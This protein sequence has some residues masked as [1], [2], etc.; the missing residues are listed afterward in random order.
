MIQFDDKNLRFILNSLD[1]G[2][3]I[4]NQEGYTIFY[5]R[6]VS[7]IDGLDP[8]EVLG[9]NV[10]ETYP[11]LTLE[12]STLMKTLKENKGISN[13]QQTFIN[14]RGEKITTI[15]STIPLNFE[16]GE[17]GAM[18]VSRDITQLKELVNNI[19]ALR[20]DII[21]KRQKKRSIS[22]KSSNSTSYSFKDIVGKSKT[23]QKALQMAIKAADSDSSVLLAGETGTGKE[24]F[25]QGIHSASRRNNR[26]FIA[27]NC[28]A[29]PKD[30]L[31]GLLFGTEK[32]GFTGARSRAGLFEDADGGSILL[33][34]INA[35][36]PA[37][38]AKLLRV[39][40][41]KKVR[42]IGGQ[43]EID[44]NVRIIATINESAEKTLKENKLREDLFYRLSV[45][46]I[47][48][49]PLRERE[50]DIQL[51]TEH[52]INNYNKKFSRSIKG[53]TVEMRKVFNNY[54]WPGNVRELQHVIESSFN[55]LQNVNKLGVDAI[56]QYI[57]GRMEKKADF[58]DD[59]GLLISGNE[60][61]PLEETLE[62]IEANLIQ[63]ALKR[64]AGN[65]SA[66]ARELKISRQS[67]QYKIK[68]Y[69]L[70]IVP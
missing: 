48:I 1:E 7:E 24:L 20:T 35:M 70:T 33:D 30:L 60:L 34:E 39:L 59:L 55:I 64:T 15:N 44:I 54:N 2:I 29:L 65:I 47:E 23:I 8:E 40:Q 58:K 32:G 61:P 6:K 69:D 25:A 12:T 27:Q 53:I 68:K 45:V 3:H 22:Q 18:E 4:V 41:E 63:M 13:Y 43:K 51:L 56:P 19:N 66:A 10:F 11:S 26:P 14:C 49:P 50:G 21:K 36:D 57:K 28:A 9:K 62:N 5:N 16:N 67:L 17:T 42:R 46:Y 31:E 52:F 37:L 38:Q